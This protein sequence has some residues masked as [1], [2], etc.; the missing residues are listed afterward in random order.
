MVVGLD[1]FGAHFGDY[2]DRY[3]LI[4]GAASWLV[5]DAA[6]LEP[7]ATKDLDI[8]LCV[9]ALDPAFGRVFWEFIQA[10]GYKVQEKSEGRKIFYRFRQPTQPGY[11]FMLELFSRKP[12]DLVLGDDSHLTPIP[13]GEDVSSL[14]AIL[15]NEAYYDFLHNNKREIE[16]ISIVSEECLIPLK[17]H[18]WLDLTARKAKGEHVDS[19]DINKHRSDVLRLYQVL[20]PDVRIGLPESVRT[21]LGD[22]LRKIQ[23]EVTIKL[24]NQLGIKDVGL[25]ELFETIR[26]IYGIPVDVNR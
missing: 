21:D 10:A 4:G 5:L 13:L 12:D 8:V 11:P 20:H 14:S 15:L 18:A 25:D 19:K 17:A 2:K 7:R 22:F 26:M 24:L 3:V 23:P 9:E 16:G 1:V 6:G